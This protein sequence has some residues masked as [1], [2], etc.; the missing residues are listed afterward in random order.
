MV[1]LTI[2]NDILTIIVGVI[3]PY[4]W[5]IVNDILPIIVG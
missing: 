2:M 5:P 3:N 4:Y 1:W